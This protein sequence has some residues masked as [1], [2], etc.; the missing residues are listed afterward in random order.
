M[1][2]SFGNMR[3]HTLL[4]FGRPAVLVQSS[5]SDCVFSMSDELFARTR[6]DKY[7][8]RDRSITVVW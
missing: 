8:E 2:Q 1:I 7:L 6:S 3:T 5:A 4:N